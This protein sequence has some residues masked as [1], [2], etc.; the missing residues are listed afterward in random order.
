MPYCIAT[1]QHMTKED[2]SECPNCRFPALGRH[3]KEVVS[4]T[5]SCPMCAAEMSADQI[6]V[7]GSS[8]TSDGKGV[9]GLA[10]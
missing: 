4:V 10:V 5:G 9:G 2:W 3:L 8:V 7:K 1:G 6:A